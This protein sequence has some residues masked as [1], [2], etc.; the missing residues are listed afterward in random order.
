MLGKK[1]DLLFKLTAD[2]STT[3]T[4]YITK[5]HYIQEIEANMI[6]SYT[7]MSKF[8]EHMPVKYLEEAALDRQWIELA[9][10]PDSKWYVLKVPIAGYTLDFGSDINNL[11]SISNTNQIEISSKGSHVTAGTTNEVVLHVPITIKGLGRHLFIVGTAIS[12][13]RK[14]NIQYCF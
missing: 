5:R 2:H 11:T 14:R 1:N 4:G 9:N 13:A 3:S 10:R 8:L 7:I 6:N 12:Y